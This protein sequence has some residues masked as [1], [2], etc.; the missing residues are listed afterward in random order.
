[1]QLRH[2]AEQFSLPKDRNR[3]VELVLKGKGQTD[4]AEHFGVRCLIQQIF[5]FP[6]HRLLQ[7]I[8]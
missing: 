2:E 3:I 1:M 4:K 7:R 6:A 5:Q 8:L